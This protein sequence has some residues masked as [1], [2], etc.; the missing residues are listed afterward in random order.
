MASTRHG[1]GMN[2]TGEAALVTGASAGLGKEVARQLARKGARVVMVAR[3]KEALDAAVAEIRAETGNADVHGLAFDVGEKEAIHRI[4][5][6][7]AA[8]IG[9]PSIVIHNA[10]TLGPVPMRLLLDTDCEELERVLAVNLVG[11]FR[12]TKALAGPMVLAKRGV[13]VFV[14]SDAAVSAYA[15]WGSYG[16]SKAAA[17]QLART[18]A[19]EVEGVRFYAFDPGDMDTKMHADAIP[20]ADPKTLAR[21]ADVAA[22]L[23]ALLESDRTSGERVAA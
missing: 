6:A 9:S 20:E 3:G 8:L 18:F 13:F 1:E 17:D 16:V 11:P 23:V 12:L 2:I 4:A 7:A 15:R 14:S 22:R 10:S 5:G 19:A 21:P